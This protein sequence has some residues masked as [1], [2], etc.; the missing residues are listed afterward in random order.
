MVVL[1]RLSFEENVGDYALFISSDSFV[2]HWCIVSTENNDEDGIMLKIVN[3]IKVFDTVY[4]PTTDLLSM[5]TYFISIRVQSSLIVMWAL[6]NRILDY[7]KEIQYY[8]LQCTVESAFCYEL[9]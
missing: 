6:C 2:N 3:K 9:W 5:Y 4:F 1:V 7:R 8:I